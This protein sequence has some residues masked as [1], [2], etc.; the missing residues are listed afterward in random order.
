MQYIS[1][2]HTWILSYGVGDFFW[3][4]VAEFISIPWKPH[5]LQNESIWTLRL[6]DVLFQIV[7]LCRCTSTA[8]FCVYFHP[9]LECLNNCFMSET[10][11]YAVFVGKYTQD[12]PNTREFPKTRSSSGSKAKHPAPIPLNH[13]DIDR[14]I[15]SK[16]LQDL[17]A[18]TTFHQ[19]VSDCHTLPSK[20]NNYKNVAAT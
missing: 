13:L 10:R 19:P 17:L 18:P 9:S 16:V 15:I 1:I 5:I 4:A 3:L 2:L 20:H 11:T 14:E 12:D 6:R 7:T 8:R